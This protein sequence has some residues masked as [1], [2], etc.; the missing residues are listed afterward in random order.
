MHPQPRPRRQGLWRQA[1]A[2]V[3]QANRQAKIARDKGFFSRKYLVKLTKSIP[4]IVR[5]FVE[6]VLHL[7]SC[8]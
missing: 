1:L 3:V 2:A 5:A 8:F 7:I 4:R 6:P